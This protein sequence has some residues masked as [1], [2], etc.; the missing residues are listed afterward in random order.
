MNSI[1]V[2]E[3][4]AGNYNEDAGEIDSLV[5]DFSAISEELLASIYNIAD[6]LGSILKSV[7]ESAQGTANIA[8]RVEDVRQTSDSVNN[9]LKDANGIVGR[10]N[11]AAG[12][13]SV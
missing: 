1:E 5:S 3:K 6:S 2:F 8:G 10:L 11:V 13:F 7:Q 4:I 12:K 9:S